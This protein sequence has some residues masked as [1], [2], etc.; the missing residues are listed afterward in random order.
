MSVDKKKLKEIATPLP[1][2]SRQRM[3]QRREE[4]R[5]HTTSA[6]I[7]AKVLRQMRMI[8]MTRVQ[9]AEK[10]GITPANITRYLNGKCNF[11]LLTL[12]EMEHVLGINIIDRN[13]IPPK[14]ENQYFIFTVDN[15]TDDR[16][17]YFSLPEDAIR[18]IENG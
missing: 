13:I 5:L 12:V 9:L 1:E 4:R 15:R 11:E 8:G 2:R 14:Q 16:E 18:Y 6:A 3:N 17:E 7:A 10:L